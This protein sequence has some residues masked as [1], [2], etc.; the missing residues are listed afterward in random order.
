MAFTVEN[1]SQVCAN[2]GHE[3]GVVVWLNHYWERIAAKDGA[4]VHEWRVFEEC[5][6]AIQAIISIQKMSS[7]TSAA[8]F[9]ALLKE[10]VTFAEAL[11]RDSEFHLL[12]R[13][14]LRR[15]R[16]ALFQCM[17]EAFEPVDDEDTSGSAEL[18][19]AN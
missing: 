15:I 9:S 4:E 12:S 8:D 11:E 3:A 2:H 10:N 19:L 7:D 5:K 1:L 18:E 6:H 16:E 14:R 13:S 17:D